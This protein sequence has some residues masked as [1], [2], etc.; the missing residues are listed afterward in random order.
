MAL[1][2]HFLIIWNNNEFSAPAKNSDS[3]EVGGIVDHTEPLLSFMWTWKKKNQSVWGQREVHHRM[4]LQYQT[5]RGYLKGWWLFHLS[6]VL[7]QSTA[8]CFGSFEWVDYT[9]TYLS[10]CGKHMA[11]YKVADSEVPG[12]LSGASQL[13][14][15][16]MTSV[17]SRASTS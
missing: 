14:A 1:Y 15:L 17:W 7:Q 12:W 8:S 5:L 6:F 10:R 4:C 2:L 3:V 9:Y 16:V 11:T 13:K